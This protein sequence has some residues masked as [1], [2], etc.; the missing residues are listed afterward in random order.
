M[1]G[2]GHPIG[3]TGVAQ[4]AEVVMQLQNKAG[5]RQ[6]KNCRNGL[7]HNLSAAATSATVVTMGV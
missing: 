1:I 3:A 5:N 7:I 4:A 6:V 2:S